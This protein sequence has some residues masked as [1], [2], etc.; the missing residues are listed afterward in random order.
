MYFKKNR[1]QTPLACEFFKIDFV[2][3][4]LKQENNL[5]N[6]VKLSVKNKDTFGVF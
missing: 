5:R 4:K 6:I 1:N 3:K 2:K